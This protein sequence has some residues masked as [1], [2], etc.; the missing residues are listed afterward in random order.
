MLGPGRNPQ[1]RNLFEIVAYLQ[2]KEG[3]RLTTRIILPV[4]WMI[5]GP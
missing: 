4:S 1:A 3:L 2:K 5:A